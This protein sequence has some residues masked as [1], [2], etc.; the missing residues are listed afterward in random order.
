MWRAR[1]NGATLSP[2]AGL[3]SLTRLRLSKCTASGVCI[4]EADLEVV[5]GS[6]VRLRR[7]DCEAV[8]DA[9]AACLARLTELRSRSLRRC[10][11]LGD[12]VLAHLAGVRSLREL[13]LEGTSMA[14][15]LTHLTGLAEQSSLALPSCRALNR[16]CWPHRGSLVKLR[17]LEL[18]TFGDEV[19]PDSV[20]GCALLPRPPSAVGA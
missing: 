20:A 15:G 9:S 16:A 1:G 11:A 13:N 19:Y 2:L 4:R 3:T 14:Q 5:F 7:L 10:R 18:S 6:L 8:S 12:G 17:C